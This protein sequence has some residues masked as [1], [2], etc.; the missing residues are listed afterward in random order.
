MVYMTVSHFNNVSADINECKISNSNNCDKHGASCI[1][2]VGSYT[3]SCNPGFVG[4]G[5]TCYSMS[6]S[7]ISPHSIVAI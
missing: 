6:S 3:C 1:N 5:I 7:K 2:T 4:N